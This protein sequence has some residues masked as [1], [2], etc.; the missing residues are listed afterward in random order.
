MHECE[1]CGFKTSRLDAFKRHQ[2]RKNP[3]KNVNPI[4]GNVNPNGDNVNPNGDNVNP[5]GENVNPIG[6]NVNPYVN[7]VNPYL[8]DDSISIVASKYSCE[9]CGKIFTTRQ[10]KSRHKIK[11]N[12]KPPPPVVC[13]PVV[14]TPGPLPQREIDDS[15]NVTGCKRDED[16]NTGVNVFED[17]VNVME[18]TVNAGVNVTSV[19]EKVNVNPQKVNR[20]PE[21][22]NLNPQKVN[23][24]PEEVTPKVNPELIPDPAKKALQ[25]EVC[26]KIFSSRPAKS[27]HKRNIDCYPP[28]VLCEPVS[29]EAETPSLPLQEEPDDSTTCPYCEKVFSRVDNLK[30]H[31][32]RCKFK[33]SGGNITNNHN[34]TTNN[35]NINTT[36]NTNTNCHNTTNNIT[37]NYNSYDKPCIDHVTKEH[38]KYLYLT[39]N[40]DLKKLIYAGVCEI[41]KTKE[42]NSFKLPFQ[43]KNGKVKVPKKLFLDNEPVEV[44]ADGKERLFP[45]DHVVEVVLQKSAEVIESYLRQHYNEETIIGRGVLKHADVLEELACNFR[46]VWDD[47]K[48]F[49]SG[50]KPFVRTA[51]LECMR[52]KE[53]A[54]KEEENEEN[55]ESE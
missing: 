13:Q 6:E 2:N 22:V 17:S 15:T 8:Q 24:N 46:E 44:Y 43:K 20:N 32:V 39:N 25:C 31:M 11:A 36:N 40:R 10:A 34:N 18:P 3:C 12:C 52:E 28:P 50:Y 29:A 30:R 7:H 27:R 21:E 48:S 51:L 4:G 38:V 47:D 49:R 33:N 16:V 35:N 14:E 19:L 26:L 53:D 1:R 37:I 5:I 23:L 54:M 41:W 42:N 55:E 9:N 45:A